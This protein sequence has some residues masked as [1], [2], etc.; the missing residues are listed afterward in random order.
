MSF[1]FRKF[2]DFFL[3]FIGDFLKVVQQFFFKTAKD[4]MADIVENDINPE[5][6]SA[7]ST[8]SKYNYTLT[9]DGK[10]CL[11]Y[12]GAYQCRH[13]RDDLA[14]NPVSDGT[15]FVITEES[16]QKLRNFDYTK[17][18]PRNFNSN[19]GAYSEISDDRVLEFKSD[20]GKGMHIMHKEINEKGV[21]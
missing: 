20:S 9:D 17:N 13:M 19:N 10:L 14:V 12:M 8:S 16:M 2:N 1:D 18:S 6:Y 4:S 5:M 11:Q 7:D 3:V 15:K 21:D